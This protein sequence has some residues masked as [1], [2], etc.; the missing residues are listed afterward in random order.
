MAALVILTAISISACKGK[1]GAPAAVEPL[2]LDAVTEVMGKASAQ[3]SGVHELTKTADG[4]EINYHLYLPTAQ[5]FDREIG[6]DLAPKI[7]RLYKT[8]P[9]LDLVTFSVETPDVANTSE[10]RPYCAFDMTRKVYQQLN[11]TNLLA[12]DL[13]KVCKVTYR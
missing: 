6:A 11:W 12:R 10:W 2:S 4:Y 7:E 3:V 5:D 8:F 13:F 1:T 9:S